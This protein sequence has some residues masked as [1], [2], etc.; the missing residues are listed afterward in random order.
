MPASV[1]ALSALAG[2]RKVY[3]LGAG[4]PR[5]VIAVSRFTIAMSYQ[6][7]TGAIPLSTVAGFALS[8]VRSGPSKCTSP[9]KASVTGAS[10][11]V[12]VVAGARV[13]V[14]VDRGGR[15]VAVDGERFVEPHAAP[16]TNANA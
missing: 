12:V 3:C 10:A 1:S 8:A 6:R 9:P 13:E 15:D 11:R 16:A 14:V 7:S 2:A 5:S 4:V